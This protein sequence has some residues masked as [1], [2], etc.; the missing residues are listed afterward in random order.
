MSEVLANSVRLLHLIVT[1]LLFISIFVDNCTYKLVTLVIM[2]FLILQYIILQG[3]CGLTI[4][5]NDLRGQ[6]TNEGFMY[7]IVKKYMDIPEA[8]INF[9]IA[10]THILWA[11]VLFIQ[12]RHKRCLNQ[13]L[14]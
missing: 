12:I 5:E 9:I 11:V 8:N 3:N 6:P 2:V 4:I 10:F 1:V 13:V 14:G 7:S